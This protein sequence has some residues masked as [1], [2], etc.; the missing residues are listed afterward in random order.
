ME[1]I[2]KLYLNSLS[3]SYMHQAMLKKPK[4]RCNVICIYFL[5]D[6]HFKKCMTISCSIP[7]SHCLHHEE[8]VVELQALTYN[9]EKQSHRW[10]RTDGLCDNSADWLPLISVGA[11]LCSLYFRVF[12][13]CVEG[14]KAGQRWCGNVPWTAVRYSNNNN[15]NMIPVGKKWRDAVF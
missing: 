4:K 14:K 2:E 12:Y 10:V 11:L 15:N 8:S 6:L 9:Q 5:F 13:R 3:H 1:Y 7:A